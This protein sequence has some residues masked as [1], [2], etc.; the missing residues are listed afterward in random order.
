MA[1]RLIRMLGT[2]ALGLLIAATM[3]AWSR[4]DTGTVRV[5]FTKGGFIIGFGGGRG[6][7]TLRGHNY[8]F[9]VSGMSF[10]ATIGGSTNQL[11]GKALNIRSP[12]DFAGSYSAIG[13]G[14]ALAGGAAGVQLQNNSNGV[15]LQLSG[16]KLGVELS[17]S[18]SG[19]QIVME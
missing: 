19:V 1:K 6:V 18:V 16:I 8:P 17:A 7:L 3:P 9:R 15:L 12:A 4:A 11:A 10:G 13:A 14:G 2:A 5:E